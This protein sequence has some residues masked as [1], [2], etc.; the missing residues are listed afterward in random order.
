[1]ASKWKQ[2][3]SRGSMCRTRYVMML[4]PVAC[5]AS[6]VSVVSLAHANAFECIQQRQ[7]DAGDRPDRSILSELN[8]DRQPRSPELRAPPLVRPTL[9]AD[10]AAE[11]AELEARIVAIE[12]SWLSTETR[13]EQDAKLGEAIEL[14]ERLLA[15]R[16]QHQGNTHEA[17]RWRN[18]AGDPTGGTT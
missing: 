12:A 18:A 16:R 9:L 1:M 6:A 4:G 7:S 8:F 3:A 10:A 17:V 5:I 14:A 15:I 13:A 11:V 2:N